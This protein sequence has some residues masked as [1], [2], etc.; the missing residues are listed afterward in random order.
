MRTGLSA[1]HQGHRRLLGHGPAVRPERAGAR[2]APDGVPRGGHDLR[3][4]LRSH[5]RGRPS[6]S[7]TRSSTTCSIRVLFG[8]E[9]KDINFSF[10]VMHRRVLESIELKS[11]GS[12]I[13]AELVVKAI[14][15]GF[16][17]F[18]MGVDYFPRT[19]GVSTLASPGG[20]R[21]DGA[22]AG[23]A[24]RRHAPPEDPGAAGAAAAYVAAFRVRRRRLARSDP[25]GHQRRRSRPSPAH[26]RRHLRGAHRRG[27]DQR[28]RA[29]H[30]PHRCRSD[31]RVGQTSSPRAFTSASPPT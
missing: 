26:R 28:D 7:S 11:Q 1:S 30:R 6:G 17:V 19:R 15:K 25:A 20:D 9:I 4:P 22:G 13:D 23:C 5:Q 10:K 12:F 31:S 27:G 29:R 24:V 3:L 8:V 18:Q 14:R 2:A 16:S 21:E